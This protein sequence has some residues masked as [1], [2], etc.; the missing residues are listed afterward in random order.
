MQEGKHPGDPRPDLVAD[1]RHWARV[2]YNTWYI[3]QDVY[4]LLHGLRSGGAELILSQKG[5]RLMPGEWS[6]EEW[7]GD[8]KNQLNP[9]KD[10]L[11]NIFRQ[12]RIGKVT[13][14]IPPEEWAKERELRK[15]NE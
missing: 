8:I 9:F 7:E 3:E 11:V 14:I 1:H 4:F 2:L 10:K 13:D 15:Q 12:T 5:Y 6:I